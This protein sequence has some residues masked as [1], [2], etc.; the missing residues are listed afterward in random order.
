MTNY[1]ELL[2]DAFLKVKK[3]DSTGER[4]E[5]PKVEG[6]FEGKKTVIL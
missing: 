5:I 6:H 3:T 1:E 4:F 2:E